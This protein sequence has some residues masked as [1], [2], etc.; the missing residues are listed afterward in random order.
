[1][2]PRAVLF[3]LYYTLVCER[4]DNP[5]YETVAGELGLALETFRP[6][7]N[8]CGRP[9]MRGEL[10][11]MVGRVTEACRLAGHLAAPEAIIDVVERNMEL[12]YGSVFIYGDAP[13]TLRRL[14]AGGFRLAIVS[15]AS[16]YSEEVLRRSGLVADV[17]DIVMSYTLGTL[18]PDPRLYTEACQRL[19]VSPGDAIYVG[20]G[21]DDELEGARRIGMG[22]ILVDRGLRHTDAARRFADRECKRLG[23]VVS[24]MT[25]LTSTLPEARRAAYR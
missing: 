18:K 13:D 23:E 1:M 8:A 3:D 9:T 16:P 7:Y 22:T 6:H 21:G 24:A 4:E 14:R 17:D 11:G 25:D 12:F 19:G 20:D 5:F 2:N 10:D 15:N